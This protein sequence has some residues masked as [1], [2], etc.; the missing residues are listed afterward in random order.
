MYHKI[1]VALD[2]TATDAV[3]LSHIV[4]FAKLCRAE[5]LL[6]HV[7]DG[8]AAR[9]YHELNLAE[10]EEMAN[11]RAYLERTAVTLREHGLTVKTH[12]A[13]GEP[14]VELIKVVAAEKCELI[15]MTS[16]GHKLLAD[17]VHGSTIDK[18]RH[19]TDVPLLIVRAMR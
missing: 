17:L 13:L 11:D 10:S 7:A 12:L 18:V 2:N 5:L 16:H 15:A 19:K 4:E 6:V 9:Q 1:L 8:F 3:M 14:A